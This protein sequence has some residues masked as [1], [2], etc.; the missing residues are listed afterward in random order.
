MKKSNVII[1]VVIILVVLAIFGYAIWDAN[2]TLNQMDN[3][4][5]EQTQGGEEPGIQDGN[6][7]GNG[8]GSGNTNNYNY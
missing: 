8:T 5:A 4:N 2:R 7:N 3:G 6:N 1:F